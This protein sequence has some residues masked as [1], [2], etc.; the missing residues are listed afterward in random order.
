MNVQT[1]GLLVLVTLLVGC[2]MQKDYTL[3]WPGV[4]ARG[5]TL[6][7]G[8]PKYRIIGGGGH[9]GVRPPPAFS[10]RLPGGRIIKP[11]EF[12]I[13]KLESH[14]AKKSFY[15]HPY[16]DKKWDRTN[17]L[18]ESGAGTLRASFDMQNRLRNFS[19]S[20]HTGEGT[21]FVGDRSGRRLMPL[22]ASRD[23]LVELFG[24]PERESAIQR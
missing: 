4:F 8:D 5:Y 13:A 9:L 6:F 24:E 21:V 14:G 20:A 18:I 22:P 17:L 2:G 3:G 7:G 23:E 19:I 11:D 12:T 16:D 1:R 15:V 10:V